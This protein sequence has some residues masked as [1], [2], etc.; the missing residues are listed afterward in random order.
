MV[1]AL[2]YWVAL[3]A[4][5]ASL[6]PCPPLSKDL[7]SKT[8]RDNTVMITVVDKVLYQAWV[9]SQ[10][11]SSKQAGITYQWIAALDKQTAVGLRL[12]GVEH[13]F[14]PELSQIRYKM[15]HGERDTEWGGKHWHETT[16]NKVQVVKMVYDLGFHVVH[17]DSDVTWFRDPHPF[18]MRFISRGQDPPHMV[19]SLDHMST[20]NVHSEWDLERGSSP[21]LSINTGVYLIKQWAHSEAFFAEWLRWYSPI[22]LNDQHALNHLIRGRAMTGKKEHPEPRWD[23]DARIVWAAF[24]ATA[25]ISFLP[26]SMFSNSYMYFKARAHQTLNHTLYGVHWVWS[27]AAH[28]KRANMRDARVYVDQPEYY[29]GPPGQPPLRLLSMHLDP[30]QAP[31]GFNAWHDDR[32]EDMVAWHVASLSAQ[33]GALYYGV[34]GALVANRTLVLPRMSCFCSRNWFKMF[35]CRVQD[36]RHTQ[37]PYTCTMQDVLR[38]RLVYQGLTLPLPQGNASRTIHVREYSFLE[39]PRTPDDTKRSRLVVMLGAGPRAHPGAPLAPG[40]LQVERRDIGG[41]LRMPWP[42][43]AEV[44]AD[45]VAQL[46]REWAVVHLADAPRLLSAGYSDPGASLRYDYAIRDY[47]TFWCCRGPQEM[48]KFGKRDREALDFLPLARRQ[49]F[50][51][52]QRLSYHSYDRPMM[53]AGSV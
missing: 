5:A 45:A 49:L 11:A 40:E 16:W 21:F 19:L 7:L 14:V 29:T 24:N 23:K 46:G 27:G 8:A 37:F 4:T 26:S 50:L 31:P 47:A 39:N 20:Q 34:M 51:A 10:L 42:V 12:L 15:H 43:T 3:L 38:T 35:A 9:P 32:S 36:E 17:A 18:F 28:N 22:N 53:T 52:G 44:F 13:C 6:Q 25:G 48:A 1:L 33:L 41:V 30:V 2:A